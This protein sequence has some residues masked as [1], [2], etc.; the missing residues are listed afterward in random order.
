M[1]DR[2][3]RTMIHLAAV[4]HGTSVANVLSRRNWRKDKS[5]REV[6]AKAMRESG[7]S[8]PAIGRALNRHHST[9]MHMCGALGVRR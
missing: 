6:A 4:A 9:V 1:L 7:M 8:W 2:E 3:T 5:A